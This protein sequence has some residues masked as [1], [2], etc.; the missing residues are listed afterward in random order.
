MAS[1]SGVWFLSQVTLMDTAAETPLNLLLGES[2]KSTSGVPS[3]RCSREAWGARSK[4]VLA[5]VESFAMAAATPVSGRPLVTRDCALSEYSLRSNAPSAPL[6]MVTTKNMREPESPGDQRAT[7]DSTGA[8]LDCW[9]FAPRD[10]AQ[11]KRT[12]K[13]GGGVRGSVSGRTTGGERAVVVSWCRG[14]V[15]AKSEERAAGR[16]RTSVST[17]CSTFP[18]MPLS[19]EMST[20]TLQGADA[21]ELRVG[22]RVRAKD[23]G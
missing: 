11:K 7:P 9:N 10:Y 5:N 16:R 23:A 8:A 22:L 13:G 14:V 18:G 20:S 21:R 2:R 3:A 15:E 12:E 17:A 4:V 6:Y 19:S 1:A